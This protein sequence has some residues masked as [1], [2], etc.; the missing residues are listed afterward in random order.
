MGQE[1]SPAIPCLYL[2]A[3]PIARAIHIHQQIPG[4]AFSSPVVSNTLLRD[5]F[6]VAFLGLRWRQAG[7]PPKTKRIAG[8]A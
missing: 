5:L 1:G 7:S 8:I 6:R 2:A 3:L 4:E